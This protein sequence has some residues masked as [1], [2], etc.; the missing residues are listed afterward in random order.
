MWENYANESNGICLCFNML[1]CDKY[2]PVE[3][4]NKKQFDLTNSMIKSINDN[5]N[6]KVFNSI[7]S[8]Q[9]S[10]LPLVLKDKK[11]YKRK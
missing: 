10:I 4:I 11:I 3:Y 1:D 7:E 9:L 2:F 8:K 5:A 6:G